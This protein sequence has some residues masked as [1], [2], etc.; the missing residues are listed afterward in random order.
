MLGTPY[1]PGATRAVLLG[2][3]ELGKEI[4]I[5]LQR[6]GVEV[7]AVDRYDHAPAMHVAHSSR[8]ISMLDGAELEKLLDELKPDLVIPEIEAIATDALKKFEEKGVRVV[9][10]SKATQITMDRERIRNL[11]AVELGLPT[12]AYVFADTMDE[13]RAGVKKI[14]IPCVVKPVMS[15]S[16]KGQSVIRSEDQI[17]AAWEC[18]HNEGRGKKNRVIIEEF[19]HFDYEITLLTV[20]AADGI[21]FCEPI[22]IGRAHV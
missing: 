10:C 16:G 2:S 22:E 19:L 18:A 8:V 17:E 6:L 20:S 3:G 11:S 13:F 7:I 14:G 15:S 21:H 5:E 9:P 1:C 12:S 4:A